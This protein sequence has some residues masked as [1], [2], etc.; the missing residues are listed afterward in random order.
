[1]ELWAVR[2]RIVF[3]CYVLLCFFFKKNYS[4]LWVLIWE[5]LEYFGVRS[6]CGQSVCFAELFFFNNF[7]LFFLHRTLDQSRAIPAIKSERERKTINKIIKFKKK[8]QI[9][10]QISPTNAASKLALNVIGRFKLF[11]RLAKKYYTV[12]KAVWVIAWNYFCPTFGPSPINSFI[13]FAIA[14]N[15]F[16]LCVIAQNKTNIWRSPKTAI[17]LS[18]LM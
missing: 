18:T 17:S 7:F 4:Y 6:L 5:S 10:L 2:F 9:Y 16:K 14:Q 1:M 8:K 15:S 11:R 3:V 13:L 12:G